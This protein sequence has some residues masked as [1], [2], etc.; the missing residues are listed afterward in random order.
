MHGCP[1]ILKR[2]CGSRGVKRAARGEPV[3][4]NARS[5][6]PKRRYTVTI[7]A[8][9]PICVLGS[10]SARPLPGQS[11][12]P[13]AEKM[14]FASKLGKAFQSL[15]TAKRC[16]KHGSHLQSPANVA[17]DATLPPA[18]TGQAEIEADVTAAELGVNAEPAPPE[19]CERCQGNGEIVTDWE[20]YRHPHP[21]DKGD[22]A[23][24]ECPDCG[25]EGI[26]DC[27]VTP[28]ATGASPSSTDGGKNGG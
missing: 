25:G 7:M 21:G 19:T 3:H 26:I 9:F 20:R 10:G 22:E 18:V 6:S 1:L 17:S 8:M 12:T 11:P 27:A 13:R 2:Y 16:S 24:A 14:G 23:V 4:T 28:S 5:L 15:L